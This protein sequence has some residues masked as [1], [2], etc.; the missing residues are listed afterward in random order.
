[1]YIST[2]ISLL[3]FRFRSFSRRRFFHIIFIYHPSTW[4]SPSTQRDLRHYP[5]PE[6]TR[7]SANRYRV[8]YIYNIVSRPTGSRPDGFILPSNRTRAYD[9][10]SPA[11][12]HGQWWKI[13][14]RGFSINKRGSVLRVMKKKTGN[15]IQTNLVC[16]FRHNY[17]RTHGG[18]VTVAVPKTDRTAY[19]GGRR[20]FL[21]LTVIRTIQA[22]GVIVTVM[23][24]EN[25]KSRNETRANNGIV[26]VFVGTRSSVIFRDRRKYGIRVI[27]G[28]KTTRQWYEIEKPNRVHE[29]QIEN[30][31]KL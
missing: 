2:K 13:V 30:R 1:M 6:T 24:V 27:C 18:E 28:W 3:P 8:I 11:N 20:R 5:T 4:N 9:G 17:V 21:R 25:G 26:G 15:S 7:R 23:V 29:S 12:P 19:R 31:A 14:R 16:R 10:R 22:A